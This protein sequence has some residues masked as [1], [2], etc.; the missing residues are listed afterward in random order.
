MLRRTAPE[1]SDGDPDTVAAED[2]LLQHL[3]AKVG[4]MGVHGAAARA[5]RLESLRRGLALP[6][7]QHL[8]RCSVRRA[9]D[10]RGA[11]PRTREAPG[12]APHPPPHR[13]EPGA[14]GG[15]WPPAGGASRPFPPRLGPG[16]EDRV[17]K[18]ALRSSGWGEVARQRGTWAVGCCAAWSGQT[19]CVERVAESPALT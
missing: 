8:A 11:T 7:P 4:W 19:G 10:P 12:I 6:P 14:Q 16:V 2:D 17:P 5:L 13:A 3:Q 9:F 18:L 1:G 15:A